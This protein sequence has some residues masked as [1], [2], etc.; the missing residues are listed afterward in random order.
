M[1]FKAHHKRALAVTVHHNHL[2]RIHS[3]RELNRA[4]APQTQSSHGQPFLASWSNLRWVKVANQEQEEEQST[5]ASCDNLPAVHHLQGEAGR[6]GQVAE[7]LPDTCSHSSC[8]T[9]PSPKISYIRHE[10][11]GG[12]CGEQH[13]YL[14]H[15]RTGSAGCLARVF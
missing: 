4:T 10:L 9:P 13:E 7:R 2:M 12:G 3:A 15:R 14:V 8:P 6:A 1:R 5:V 11:N